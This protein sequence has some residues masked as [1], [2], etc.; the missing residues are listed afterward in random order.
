MWS[1]ARA[2]RNEPEIQ[3]TVATACAGLPDLAFKRDG[4]EYRVVGLRRKL[5]HWTGGN[6][7]LGRC[8][9]IVKQNQP[10]LVHIHGTERMFG[11]IGARRWVTPPVVISLQGLIGPIARKVFGSLTWGQII[12]CHRF[13]EVVRGTGLA[14]QSLSY[15]KCGRREKVILQGN[16]YFMGRTEWDQAHLLALNPDA[17]YY[18]CGEILREEFFNNEW[19][20][21]T[22]QRHNL[23]FTNASGPLRG[24]EDILAAALILRREF[25]DLR[26]RLAGAVDGRSG[27][28]RFLR[29]RVRQLGLETCLE[30]LGYLDAGRMAL[31]LARSHVFV[32]ASHIENS[33]NSLSEAQLTGLPCV[34]TYAGGIPSL[35]QHEKTGLLFPVGDA[36]MLASRI[37][38][39][40]LDDALAMALGAAARARA[41]ERHD[42]KL[43]LDQT[44]AAYRAVIHAARQ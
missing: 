1:L 14:H 17:K 10:D 2:L 23:I 25:P 9:R 40:F 15:R 30:H 22:C 8:A 28:E 38:T 12:R 16:K 20:P 4:V 31:E 21:S 13:L 32:I 43:V 37:R 34:A 24:V 18:H 7:G 5:V 36:P 6:E 3:L 29:S 35:V 27:Y 44:L 33:P 19:S 11:L 41:R 26:L 42:P 39:I